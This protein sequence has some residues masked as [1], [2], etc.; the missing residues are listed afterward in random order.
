MTSENR[1]LK[2]V[3]VK[4]QNGEGLNSLVKVPD[5]SSDL[6]AS[7][8]AVDGKNLKGN[9]AQRRAKFLGKDPRKLQGKDKRKMKESKSSSEFRNN[10]L[11]KPSNGEKDFSKKGQGNSKFSSGKADNVSNQRGV[12]KAVKSKNNILGKAKLDSGMFK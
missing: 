5:V 10:S 4:R 9:R 1:F 3:A 11:M 12:E 7:Q 6:N 8:W 2:T